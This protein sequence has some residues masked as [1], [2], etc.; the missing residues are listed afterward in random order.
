MGRQR[1]ATLHNG[2]EKK[3]LAL[4]VAGGA[5]VT[6]VDAAA[7]IVE[8]SAAAVA[9]KVPKW[10]G[11]SY[12]DLHREYHNIFK[13]GNRNAASHLWS[14]FIL[15]R[16][17][18]MSHDLFVSMFSGFCAV[19]GSPVRPSD[20]TRYKMTL[21]NVDGSGMTTGYMMYCCWPCVCDTWDFIKVDTKNITTADGT[22]TYRFAVLGN[23][24]DHPEA[25]TKP[26]KDAFGRG[27]TTLSHDA[28]EV[29]CGE[30]GTLVNAPLSDHGYVIINMFFDFPGQ[31]AENKW[32]LEEAA[33]MTMQQSKRQP[34]PG[35]VSQIG[36][37]RFQDEHEYAP[38]CTQR[39]ENGYNSGMGEIFR[40]V[41]AISPIRVKEAL[42]PSGE[43]CAAKPEG[44]PKIR[45]PQ[46]EL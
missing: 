4:L 1:S 46:M 13:H 42:C 31:S 19:S 8:Q 41:A 15:E 33:L 45:E 39:A 11:R 17:D 2:L 20:Y 22:R 25:L 28:A 5:L 40:K 32:A 24:C 7:E 30:G 6:S 14:N 18:Q 12:Q 3:L 27:M 35:R 23:P 44:L 37:V 16:A 10:N 38:M 34:Q 21:Q 26:F 29:R 36:G 43:D 9:K